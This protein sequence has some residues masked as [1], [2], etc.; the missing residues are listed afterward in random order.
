MYY[1][2]KSIVKCKKMYLINKKKM[3]RNHKFNQRFLILTNGIDSMKWK[4][5]ENIVHIHGKKRISQWHV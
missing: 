2:F 4:K 1:Y 3:N 5:E